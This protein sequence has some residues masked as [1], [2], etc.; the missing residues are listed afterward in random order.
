MSIPDPTQPS[1]APSGWYPTGETGPDGLP[2]ERWWD[3]ATWSAMVR[4]LGGGDAGA[5]GA[6]GKRSS[7][8]KGLVAAAVVVVLAGIGVGAYFAV[9]G[10]NSS[11]P[12]ASTGSQPTTAPTGNGG[13]G[14]GNGGLGGGTGNGGT[15]GLGGGGTSSAS[16]QPTVTGGSGKTVADPIDALTIP[17]PSGWTGTAGSTSGNGSWPALSTGPYTCPSA[18]ASQNGTS[19][20]STPE[21]TRGGVN[22]TTTSGSSA[23]GVATGDIATMA[24]GNY[25]TLSAHTVSSQGAVTVAGR[26]GYQVTW[27]VTPNYSGPSGTVEVIALPVPGQSG[28]FTLIDIGVDQ[29]SQAP[30]LATVNSQVISAITDSSAAGA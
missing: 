20:S 29:S 16:P 11:S 28:Y 22:F 4:P 3:G 26:S 30:S 27:S 25:G 6:R 24:K 18:L 23:Q 17:V 5:P 12:T 14:G 19:S 15:G 9:S 1:S 8:F 2:V 21:C 10:N 13:F 7:A